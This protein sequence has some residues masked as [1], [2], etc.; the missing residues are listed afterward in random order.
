MHRIVA[1][2]F[3]NV[4]EKIHQ[5][6]SRIKKDAHKRKLVPVFCLSVYSTILYRVEGF[7]VCTEGTLLV[8]GVRNVI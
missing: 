1:Y 3:L 5:F 2:S 6:L 4:C 7:L 8:S